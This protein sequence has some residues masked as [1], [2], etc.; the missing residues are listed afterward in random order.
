MATAIRRRWA[1]LTIT[2]ACGAALFVP[3]LI[4]A[5]PS[6]PALPQIALFVGIATAIA[7]LGAW[8]GLRLADR[9][10]LP[11]PA[12]RAWEDGWPRSGA[13]LPVDRRAMV[14]ALLGGLAFGIAAVALLRWLHMPPVAGS[15]A[16][17]V[18]SALFAAV[19]LEV[20]V[21]LLIMSA[22]V[23]LAKRVWVGIAA[24]AVA[25]M[26]FHASGSAGQAPM[27]FALTVGANGLGGLLFGWLYGRY[28][29]EYCVLG[30]AVAHIVTLSLS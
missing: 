19:T 24:S 26:L 7:A 11:M 21:H 17:K 18:L 16:A 22:V 12:L 20:V 13:A 6:P 8:G 1:L 14:V 10:N 27:V 23:R 29:F 5:A 25:F 28:G 30:H 9:T 4:A 2:S 15:L 3:F